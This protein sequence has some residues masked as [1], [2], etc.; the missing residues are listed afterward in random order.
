[1]NKRKRLHI[2]PLEERILLDAAIAAVIAHPV[3][4]AATDASAVAA[5][6]APVN[7]ASP[8]ASQP[9][10]YV[11][12]NATGSVHDGKSWSTAYTSLQDALNRAANTAGGD[13]IWIAQ[14]TYVPSQIYAPNGV[15]GGISGLTVDQLKTFNIPDNTELYG[16]FK[17]GM[18]SLSQ[19]NPNLYPTILSGDLSGANINNPALAEQSGNAWH[20]V[21]LGND[22]TGA[23][24][25]ATLSGLTIEDG[26]ANGPAGTAPFG[27]FVYNHNFGGGVYANDSNLTMTNDNIQYNYSASDGGGVFTNDTNLAVSNSVFSHDS[28]VTRGGG[29]ESLNTFEGNTPHTSTLTNDLFENNTSTVFGGAVVG[30]GT[31]PN[32][33]SAMNIVNSTFI[34]NT[35][36]EGG[37]IT[38]DSL[39][40]NV[41]GSS[42]IGNTA[43]VTGGAIATTNIVDSLVG[44]PNQFVTTV[45]NSTFIDNTAVG[46]A[47]AR[48]AL[49]DFQGAN[50]GI[51][52]ADGGGALTTYINGHL[53]VKGS[54]FVGNVAE[55][56]DGGAILN[57]DSSAVNVFGVTSQNADTTISGSI[58]IG[59]EAST[60][61]GGAVASESDGILPAN[62]SAINLTI[63]N[64]IM[65][66]NSAANDGGGLYA[67]NSTVNDTH[68]VFLLNQAHS[69]DEL[70]AVGSVLNGHNSDLPGVLANQILKNTFLLLDSDDLFAA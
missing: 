32:L 1:M 45:T 13:Q 60:G 48:T 26:Y 9:I 5:P 54:L 31:F 35:S 27:A 41:T 21:T 57:G 16:G 52:F 20:V 11:N 23:G 47:A 3:A 6:A 58:F 67:E 7:T 28:A 40:T 8:A 49:N 51:D 70:Y 29:L 64:S 2:V 10:I 4:H 46:T 15:V 56:G 14:G 62:P 30:E 22:I 55:N 68:N 38:I 66:G 18:T 50:I 53:V 34:N 17:A 43:T 12:A 63:S 61:N 25:T 19:A 37:A 24:V 59:N 44:G 39:T 33:A 65:T 69:G 42:F 36:P